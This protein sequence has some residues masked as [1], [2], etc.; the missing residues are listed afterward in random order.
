MTDQ[1]QRACDDPK[2][3]PP[4]NGPQSARVDSLFHLITDG[5]SLAIREHAARRLGELALQSPTICAPILQRVRPLLA[6]ARWDVRVGVSRCI[7]ALARGLRSVTGC[8]DAA[9]ALEFAR[10]AFAGREASC[11]LLNCRTVDVAVVL[12]DGAPLLRSGGEE[13]AYATNLS[14]DERRVRA[15]QQRRLL[16]RRLCGGTEGATIW[17]THEDALAKRMLPRLNLDHVKDLADDLQDNEM[18]DTSETSNASKK[19]TAADLVAA[20]S[21]QAEHRADS[22]SHSVLGLLGA[23]VAD[24]LES[25]FDA[26]WEVRHGALAALRHVL[27]ATSASEG[28]SDLV[29]RWRE[30]ALM[31][32]VCVLALDQFV[33]YSADGSVAPVR[34]LCAQVLGVLLGRLEST[35]LLAEYLQVLRRLLHPSTSWHAAHGGLLGVRYLLKAH[36]ANAPELVP[37]VVDDV[38]A[39]LVQHRE[40][41][42]SEDVAVL[43]AGILG[44]A[45]RWLART[46]A[47]A[48]RRATRALWDALQP[49]KTATTTRRSGL[50]AAAAV[51]AIDC[52]YRD[53]GEALDAVP[54]AVIRG[55]LSSLEPLLHHDSTTVRVA[56]ASSLA[57]FFLIGDAEKETVVPLLARVLWQL[58]LEGSDEEDEEQNEAAWRSEDKDAKSSSSSSSSDVRDALLDTFTAIVHRL[59]RPQ[60]EQ[61]PVAEWLDLVASAQ[62]PATLRAAFAGRQDAE[63][64]AEPA[65]ER[66]LPALVSRLA[67]ADAVGELC[68]AA[69]ASR[70]HTDAIAST[71][72]GSLLSASGERKCGAL[73]VLARWAQQP[74]AP[75]PALVDTVVLQAQR[76]WLQPPSDDRQLLYSEQARLL[77]RVQAL[78]TRLL[79]LFRAAGVEP[80]TPSAVTAAQRSR[81]LAEHAAAALPYDRLA[82]DAF[83]RAH[84][85]RQDLF[86]VDEQ[87][88]QA[89]AA[90][91]ARVQGLG[92]VAV[93]ALSET[94]PRKP[95]FLVKALMDALKTE[96][97]R[98]VVARVAATLAEIAAGAGSATKC[99]AKIVANLSHS[100]MARVA[101]EGPTQPAEDEDG[102]TKRKKAKKSSEVE[103]D[104]PDAAR[105]RLEIR[106]RNAELA[107]RT[108][109]RR[110][111]A[112]DRD[113]FLACPALREAVDATWTASDEQ[114]VEQHVQ[115]ITLLATAPIA[116]SYVLAWIER[117]TELVQRAFS[118]TTT[119]PRVAAALAA[120]CAASDDVVDRETALAVV[121]ER[122][123]LPGDAHALGATLTMAQLVDRLG[124]QR[125]AAV[126]PAL[127]PLV[128]RA[129]N[130]TDRDVRPLA[131]RCF[132]QLIPL[133]PLQRDAEATAVQTS[134]LQ[135]L[136]AQQ[137]SS[138]GGGGGLVS[139]LLQGGDAI[140]RVDVG[141]LLHESISLRDYQRHGVDWLAFLV[142]HAL[143][144]VL[145]DDMGLGKTLQVLTVLAR[146]HAARP[147]ERSLVV[148]PPI[149]VAHWVHEAQRCLPGVFADVADVSARGAVAKAA[150]ST[151]SSL[152]I[153]TYAALRRDLTALA[154][155]AF[156]FVVLDEAHLVRNPQSA[157]FKAVTSLQAS[158]R[159]ALSGTP[160]QNHVGD[161]WAL[162]A[163]LL[164]GYL[165]D[166]PA[167]RRDVV[168][169][170]ARGRAR[171]ATPAHKERAALALDAL[172]QRVLP[173][174]LRRTKD[175]VLT[176]LPP[177][178]ISTRRLALSPLQQRLYELATAPEA[179]TGLSSVFSS[180]QT[181]K[182]ICVAPALVAA[183]G[184]L[185]RGLT[186]A[187]RRVL[188]DWR[189]S[190]KLVGLHD[191]LVDECD[192]GPRDDEEISDE[193]VPSD[194]KEEEGDGE[195][196]E[197]H[198]S[199]GKKNRRDKHRCL[200]FAHS[201]A[202]LDA[203]GAMLADALP[204]LTVARLDGATPSKRRQEVVQQ[205]NADASIDLLLLTT[206][207][208][209]LGLTL[210]G[211]DTVVFVEHAWNPFVDLQAMDRA[212]RIG[213][214]RTV[215]VFRLLMTASLEEHIAD[216]QDFKDRVAR[217]VVQ[218][219]SADASL[220]TS[221]QHVLSLLQTSSGVAQ[222]SALEE[223]RLKAKRSKTEAPPAL[224]PKA[225]LEVLEE[226]GEMWD[227]TQYD[228]LA[229]PE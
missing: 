53:S 191:L 102:A 80:P 212:H 145:A 185:V 172:H 97:Q 165:G 170:I 70:C 12:Q 69:W 189:Q 73:L 218:A 16:L 27:L 138:R 193:K 87:L 200:I 100:A 171:L 150:R 109:C 224:L 90:T 26:K 65:R 55:A 10:I 173:F 51:G 49:P 195:E 192:L 199:K 19:R 24:L 133:L 152:W 149:V 197:E 125:L 222:A 126:V 85:A 168:T 54:P 205:F 43:A 129:V 20:P 33:D 31:R 45:A 211:A 67:L 56:A 182:K 71:L 228:S 114:Q 38:T 95:G 183:Q 96:P 106:V 1:Q 82:P 132:A 148:C 167:F 66:G 225:A 9:I 98:V 52:W 34:D 113:V 29:R 6:D 198:Q 215:R 157:A 99:A 50:V 219:T 75:P 122:V 136:L 146:H 141:G 21:A 204:H 25:I 223:L 169:P 142:D 176:E 177:K 180:L 209:G 14:D 62:A 35:D 63:Q 30:E 160:V 115:L 11:P 121:L 57:R 58:L 76:D 147:G 86:L 23:L 134:R 206:A 94:L 17:S 2:A 39:A 48:V 116:R 175:D 22:S 110:A 161:L 144:G 119:R 174:V 159:L 15:V 108:M 92:A 207:V 8:D 18:P 118:K 81:A 91:H 78:H 84:F 74:T 37:L 181:L 83:E 103:E 179:S 72:T 184:A 7:E 88:Q 77:S 120:L 127:V 111:A 188:L 47:E 187:Q 59:D 44:D 123:L 214:R 156:A 107:L 229:F 178:I 28:S 213:Q 46:P 36:A 226:L 68:A 202:A 60:L 143:G 210:T 217:T 155:M 112:D 163:F 166:W 162:F 203:V 216:L 208:G 196:A 3:A 89:F 117:L 190:G 164:P 4:L 32:C 140:P 186:S 135:T 154:S 130:A 128:L 194:D 124:A 101:L 201:K 42:V 40:Q 221:T 220:R 79:A 153:T 5:S 227:A 41:E 104:A 93:V 158:H 139:G 151:A 137:S 13:Y 105:R 131:A 61:V 64:D